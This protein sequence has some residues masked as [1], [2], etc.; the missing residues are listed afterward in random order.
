M[1][2]KKALIGK[3]AKKAAGKALRK[4]G[5]RTTSMAFYQPKAPADLKRFKNSK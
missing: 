3:V 1:E 5:N 2:S 4:E